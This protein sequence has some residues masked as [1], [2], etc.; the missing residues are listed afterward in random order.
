MWEANFLAATR[1][2]RA[3]LAAMAPGGSI[4]TISSV[5]ASA[6]FANHAH[7]AASKAALE[8]F[9]RSLAREIGPRGMRANCV[10]PGL[11]AREGL[12]QDWPQGWS[13]WSEVAPSGHPVSQDE[14]AGVVSFLLSS[15]ASGIN[16]AV[17]PVDGGWS[18]SARTTF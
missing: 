4:V 12:E 18:A 6:A 5:E 8:S 3:A 11:I 7:Y 10:A 16:G 15:Q 9:T 2:S 13:W 14:V 17:I 1:I